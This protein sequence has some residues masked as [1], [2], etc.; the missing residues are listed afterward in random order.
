MKQSN[1]LDSKTFI[2]YWLEK[3]KDQKEKKKKKCS[4]NKIPKSPVI[5]T[6]KRDFISSTEYTS[7]WQR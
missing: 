2:L 6:P 4:Q 7:K 1:V 3:Y 5:K